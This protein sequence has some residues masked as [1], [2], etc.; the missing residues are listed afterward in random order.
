[1]EKRFKWLKAAAAGFFSGLL[2]GVFGAGGGIVAVA[3][4]KKCGL[5]AKEAHATSVAVMLALSCLISSSI[6]FFGIGEK[7]KAPVEVAAATAK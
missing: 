3:L 6:I 2:G 5:S 1:M 4:L 7:R